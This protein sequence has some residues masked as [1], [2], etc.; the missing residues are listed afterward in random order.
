MGLHTHTESWSL[1]WCYH[2]CHCLSTPA[3]FAMETPTLAASLS[4]TSTDREV[5]KR[6]FPMNERFQ[7]LG[8]RSFSYCLRARQDARQWAPEHTRDQGSLF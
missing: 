4:P 5:V 2:T 8:S 1:S 3:M 6:P 7:L